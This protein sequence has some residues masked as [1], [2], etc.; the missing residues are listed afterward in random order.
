MR[1]G[2]NR[3]KERQGWSYQGVGH[4]NSHTVSR[5]VLPV[6]EPNTMQQRYDKGTKAIF[7][8]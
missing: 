1:V 2:S 8:E 7:P 3:A 5:A 6:M 4:M